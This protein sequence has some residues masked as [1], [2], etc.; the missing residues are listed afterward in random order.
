MKILAHH[1]LNLRYVITNIGINKV[2]Q[3]IYLWVILRD[4]LQVLL[5]SEECKGTNLNNFYSPEIIRKSMFFVMI[6]RGIRVN[7]FA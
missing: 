5:Q 2:A 3:D 6:S 4:C 1:A 7:K